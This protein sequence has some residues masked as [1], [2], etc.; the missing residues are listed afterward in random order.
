MP[1]HI[2]AI[3]DNCYFNMQRNNKDQCCIIRWV[4]EFP[5]GPYPENRCWAP[6]TWLIRN[7]LSNRIRNLNDLLD[8][9][10]T[11]S[12][13]RGGLCLQSLFLVK[14]LYRSFGAYPTTQWI[15]YSFL[16]SPFKFKLNT[17]TDIKDLYILHKEWPGTT[18]ALDLQLVALLNCCLSAWLCSGLV[19]LGHQEMPGHSYGYSSLQCLSQMV[20]W[21]RFGSL[22]P[23]TLSHQVL[24]PQ[25]VFVLSGHHRSPR[26]TYPKICCIKTFLWSTPWTVFQIRGTE[27]AMQ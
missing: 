22:S 3:A 8:L 5:N 13:C 25:T 16:T 18:W 7:S 6:A 24:D 11:Y 10:S 4:P 1:P 27:K 19:D 23:P 17:S 9:P 12:Q 14:M 15:S 21:T 26:H 2:F 20:V